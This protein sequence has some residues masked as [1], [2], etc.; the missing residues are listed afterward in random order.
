MATV[1]TYSIACSFQKLR[2]CELR[3]PGSDH[4]K[5]ASGDHRPRAILLVAFF[6]D[7]ASIRRWAVSYCMII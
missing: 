1:K 5:Y 4:V 3:M 7:I 2:L 6:D